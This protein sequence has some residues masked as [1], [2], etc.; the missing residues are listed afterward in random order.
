MHGED[1]ADIRV[2]RIRASC[3]LGIGNHL[4][5]TFLCLIGRSSQL[6]MVIKTLAHFAFTIDAQYFGDF[7]GFHLWFD[8]SIGVIAIIE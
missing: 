6:D 7:G 2:A 8:Q 5:D 1:I 3:S 4:H